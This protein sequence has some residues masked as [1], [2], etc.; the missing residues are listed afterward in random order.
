MASQARSSL[1]DGLRTRKVTPVSMSTDTL[2]RYSYLDDTST[3]PLVITPA[4]AD[5]DLFGWLA[6]DRQRIAEQLMKHGALLF[7]GFGVSRPELFERFIE[8]TSGKPL[9]YMERSSPRSVVRGNI[10]TS[11]DQPPEHSIFF[12]NEQSY[13]ATF[14]LKIYF[15]CL[16]A[17]TSGGETPIADCRKV[18]E[19]LGEDLRRRFA[20]GYLYRRTLGNG[21]G[22]SWKEAFQTDSR[23]DV[24]EYCARNDI[25]CEW[26]SDD[27]LRTTQKRRVIARHPET[28][29]LVWF[30]HMTFFNSSTL[31]ADTLAVLRRECGDELPNETYH[32]D[33][34]PIDAD[35]MEKLRAAYA[36]ESRKFA[37]QE[38]DVLFVDNVLVAHSREPFA[39]P[40][41]VVVGMADPVSW[42]RAA[43]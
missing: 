26:L 11:T 18:Y 19:R 31:P 27:R 14:P 16:K 40:R 41:K 10:Y 39:G 36:A 33:G 12:H 3:L 20:D 5:V 15:C 25:N 35:V 2:V 29:E 23:K 7:R 22:L 8:T 9:N 13:N 30:N 38:G 32:A 43:V 28:K 1:A 21:F 24:E 34:T 42:D 4:T 17:S 37:W 6:T